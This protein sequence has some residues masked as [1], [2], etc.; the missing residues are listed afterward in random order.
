MLAHIKGSY[1]GT[2]NFFD[3]TAE[4][5]VT[6]ACEG[7]DEQGNSTISLT[8]ILAETES[9]RFDLLNNGNPLELHAELYDLLGNSR[10]TKTFFV[11]SGVS[12]L[13]WNSGSLPTGAYY[14]RL[15]AG[16]Y[17]ST[18]RFAISR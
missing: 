8:S 15:S 3:T 7:V 12:E 5:Q 16:N 13:E 4:T 14:L 18:S 1:K 9:L 11:A 2:N 10:G 6:F 17:R